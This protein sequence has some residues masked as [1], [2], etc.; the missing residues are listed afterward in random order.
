MTTPKL[1]TSL[2][3]EKVRKA[4]ASGAVQRTGIFPPCDRHRSVERLG[5][6]FFPN[7]GQGA[8]L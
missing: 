8:E 7:P 5:S 4:M 1:H 2:A 3:E 6:G